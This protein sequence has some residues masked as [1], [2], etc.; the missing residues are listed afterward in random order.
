MRSTGTTGAQEGLGARLRMLCTPQIL[1]KAVLAA[2]V[3]GALLIALNQG[4]VLL[5]GPLTGRLLAKCLVTP[6]IPFG[7]T[8]LG[9][10]LNSRPSARA[11]DLRPGRA[12]VRR[13]VILALLV[14][15]TLIVVNQGDV[16]LAGGI[17]PRVWMKIV[18]TPCVP[19]CVSL[20]GAYAAYWS[21]RAAEQ[22]AAR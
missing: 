6:L 18:L 20:Y 1:R 8:L 5:A 4:D 9:A 22:T 7:V 16:L 15:S 14:G 13:S 11:A 21:A 2:G 3:V 12:A 17:T 10:F 19:F